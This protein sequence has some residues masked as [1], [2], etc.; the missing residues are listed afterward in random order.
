[1][2]IYGAVA[3]VLLV[4][5]LVIESGRGFGWSYNDSACARCGRLRHIERRYGITTADR[6]DDSELS[7]W[8][9]RYRS[10]VCKH[11]WQPIA[12]GHATGLRFGHWDGRSP[13]CDALRQIHRLDAAI[14]ETET[15][16][17]LDRYDEILDTPGRGD[18]FTKLRLFR[19]ELEDQR[20]TAGCTDPHSLLPNPAEAR[21]LDTL[22]VGECLFVPA[23]AGNTARLYLVLTAEI[24]G[25]T[26]PD[27]VVCNA[28]EALDSL[29]EHE[30]S[31]PDSIVVFFILPARNSSMGSVSGF[32]RAQLKELTELPEDKAKLKVLEHAWALWE[33]PKE[34]QSK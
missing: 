20:L 6:T 23:Q 3:L 16:K 21:Y 24:G 1:M 9:S 13:L 29:D 14:G 33:M 7:K 25:R 30:G 11:D 22:G 5:L 32:T 18:R 19:K 34:M 27:I 4:L 10:G 31:G 2:R 28:Q 8:L 26:L 15:R 17:L 12:G